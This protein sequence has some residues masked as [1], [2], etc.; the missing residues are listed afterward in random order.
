MYI[1]Y[2]LDSF[3]IS[4]LLKINNNINIGIEENDI[5]K[6]KDKLNIDQQSNKEDLDT[7]IKVDIS[8]SQENFTNTIILFVR[9]PQEG[10][11]CLGPV[12]AYKYHLDIHPIKFI[13]KL[14]FYERLIHIKYFQDLIKM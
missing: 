14:L 11:A 5:E 6:E 2:K 12:E 4:R 1:K 7:D 8:N 9:R 3:I 10:Y 13:W